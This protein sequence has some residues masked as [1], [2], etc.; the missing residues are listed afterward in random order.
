MPMKTF[1]HSLNIML[2]ISI[3]NN[4]IHNQ[5]VMSLKQ[6][7]VVSFICAGMVLGSFIASLF[8]QRNSPE[9]L[10]LKFYFNY[11]ALSIARGL[12]VPVVFFS[13]NKQAR[14]HVKTTF[15]NEWAPDFIQ[16]YNPNRV[17]EIE[18]NNNPR[19]QV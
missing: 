3:M 2:F 11:N 16:V 7:F 5:D 12:L 8:I 17:V 15:W 10:A 1:I 13:M 18:L 9:N 4:A 19:I 6:D 14:R